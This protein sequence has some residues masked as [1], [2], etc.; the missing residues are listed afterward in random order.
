M[1]WE[2]P[3]TDWKPSSVPTA[4]AFN[5][6]ENNILDLQNNKR[7]K[8]STVPVTNGGTGA[9]NAE[10]ARNNL[11]VKKFSESFICSFA[12]SNKIAS[13]NDYPEE[14]GIIFKYVG[15]SITFNGIQVGNYVICSARVGILFESIT[16]IGTAVTQDAW[17]R[18]VTGKTVLG[19]VASVYKNTSEGY[20]PEC[21][22]CY[23]SIGNVY[24]S[25]DEGDSNSFMVTL[26][27]Q[28]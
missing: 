12:N 7:D 17:I 10:T 21:I 28:V 25:S 24:V 3:K 4:E 11:G 19:V 8:S 5:R 26:T 23:D 2:K 13:S 1:A 16:N 20:A 18:I 14:D 15:R 9:T 6:I 22:V 27:L